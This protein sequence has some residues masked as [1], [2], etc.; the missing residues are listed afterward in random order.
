MRCVYRSSQR[1]YHMSFVLRL[2][3]VRDF[4]FVDDLLTAAYASSASMLEDLA[5]YHRLQ[6]DGWIV[7]LQDERPVG[8]GGALLY[9][10]FAR[11]GLMAVLPEVQH[12]GIGAAI[13]QHLLE[14]ITDRGATVVLLDATPSGVP[15]YEKFGF[16]V[17]DSTCAY[18]QE[19]TNTLV[20][21]PAPGI[22][23]KG[24]EP[25]ELPE[26]VTYDAGRFGAQRTGA[27]M[28]YY[29]AFPERTFV[30]RDDQGRMVGYIVA[31]ARR[32]G[33]WVANTP[34]IAG[35]L[36]QRALDLSFSQCPTVLIPECN[37]GA[38]LLLKQAG[39][40][41]ERRWQAMRLGGVRDLSRR[42]WFYG[43]ANLYVG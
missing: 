7:T 27:L 13:M 28:S 34:D 6:P 23:T 15:L 42:Q 1:V 22:V 4:P 12:Q 8:M 16:V 3:T 5:H 2:L 32:L 37:E 18:V 41:P 25:G 40:V 19:G 33:P 20:N 14:W 24:L 21:V 29:E 30:A 17:D 39:F 36:L 43:C 31:Q 11:I 38:R 9:G 26:V 35:A 10:T